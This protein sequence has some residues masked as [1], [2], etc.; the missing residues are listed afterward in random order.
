M[1]SIEIVPLSVR[2][3]VPYFFHISAPRELIFEYKLRTIC[4]PGVRPEFLIR[5]LEVLGLDP[6]P[7]PLQMG[8]FVSFLT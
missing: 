5:G 6:E 1:C 7:D 3:S 4:L 2:P 8:F